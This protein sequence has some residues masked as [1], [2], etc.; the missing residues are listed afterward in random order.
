MFDECIDFVCFCCVEIYKDNNND[1]DYK[2]KYK[3]HTK[4]T[5]YTKSKGRKNINNKRE[6]G[7]ETGGDQKNKKRM[8]EKKHN[9]NNQN[10]S[11]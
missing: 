9:N 6:K 1:D 2:R 10:H 8:M 7:L 11:T 3:I 4:C 5:V